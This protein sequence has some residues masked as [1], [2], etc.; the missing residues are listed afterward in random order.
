MTRKMTVKVAGLGMLVA[1]LAGFSAPAQAANVRAE[2][3]FSFT[4]NGKVLPPGTYSLS[5]TGNGGLLVLPRAGSGAI[6][7]TIALSSNRETGAK[8]VFHKYGQEYV[9]RQVWSGGGSGREIP[10]SRH[11]KQ[12]MQAARQGKAVA[13]VERIVLTG[14]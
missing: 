14:F 7:L 6:A 9:L 1:V 4:V 10:T 13:S 8:L 5:S 3:P 11:E 2:V 12:L